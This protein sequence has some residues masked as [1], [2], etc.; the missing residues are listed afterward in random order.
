MRLRAVGRGGGRRARGA[1]TRVL[2]RAHELEAQV[3]L[4]AQDA[5]LQLHEPPREC[6][7]GHA[8]RGGRVREQEEHER[9]RHGP[10]HACAAALALAG[11]LQ[12][13]ACP[14]TGPRPRSWVCLAA[15]RW[16][17]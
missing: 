10:Q 9:G 8:G 3:A 12:L 17:H 4:A 11:A 7:H 16:P 1:R 14:T 5:E 15:T 13:A 2:A 6:P